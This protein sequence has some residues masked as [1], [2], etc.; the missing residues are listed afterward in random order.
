MPGQLAYGNCTSAP[1]SFSPPCGTAA[2]LIPVRQ[3]V[4]YFEDPTHNDNAAIGLN[5]TALTNPSGPI[6]LDLPCGYYH[7]TS[8]GG[9]QPITIVAHGHTA[10]F[11][12]GAI[13]TTKPFTV[14]LDPTATFDIFVG[15]VM[16]SSQEISIGNPAAA[17]TIGRSLATNSDTMAT[18]SSTRK[19]HSD[20]TPR[21]LD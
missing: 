3:I 19:I 14:N 16:V 15:G 13:N 21:R 9:S 10:L 12:S 6:R 7:L 11:V 4:Q 17:I 20:Q 1:V 18:A 5:K 8:I 2:D